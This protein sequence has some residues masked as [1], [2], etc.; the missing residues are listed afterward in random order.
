MIDKTL[1]PESEP[2]QDN[3]VFTWEV[4]DT[5]NFI[6]YSIKTPFEYKGWKASLPGT[7][8]TVTYSN[9]DDAKVYLRDAVP[10]DVFQIIADDLIV[11]EEHVIDLFYSPED[12][13]K[14]DYTPSA[15]G[16]DS[17]A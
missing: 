1:V 11:I 5:A 7:L 10:L 8:C 16:N 13:S 14:F 2:F 6:K 9:P 17:T 15:A 12:T 4:E 3:T